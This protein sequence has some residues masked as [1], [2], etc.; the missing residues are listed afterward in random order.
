MY[1]SPVPRDIIRSSRLLYNLI[2]EAPYLLSSHQLCPWPWVSLLCFCEAFW[3]EGAYRLPLLAP[4]TSQGKP[5]CM[6]YAPLGVH[7]RPAIHFT[8]EDE[9]ITHFNHVAS[10]NHPRYRVSDKNFLLPSGGSKPLGP[11]GWNPVIAQSIISLFNISTDLEVSVSSLSGQVMK[12]FPARLPAT[13]KHIK[14]WL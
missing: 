3:Q 5:L 14:T 13:Y 11:V 7:R 9:V 6:G 2:N 4:P 1:M 12:A 10:L 8:L